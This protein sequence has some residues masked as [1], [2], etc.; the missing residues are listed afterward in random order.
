MA[1]KEKNPPPAEE[2]PEQDKALPAR[3]GTSGTGTLDNLT[4]TRRA[5]ATSHK[6]ARRAER[7]YR[8]KKHA[9]TARAASRS[10]AGHYR[11]A[12]RHLWLGLKAS[13]GAARG[14]PA[15]VGERVEGVRGWWGGRREKARAERR[16]RLEEELG[17]KESSEEDPDGEKAE[18]S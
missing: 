6:A 1:K 2:T 10:A 4:T 14:G 17:K 12:L 15:V 7:A 8:N 11:E 3:P 18:G 5:A 9:A 13:F 16:R